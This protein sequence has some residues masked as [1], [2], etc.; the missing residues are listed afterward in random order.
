MSTLALCGATVVVSIDPVELAGADVLIDGDR[1]A[2]VGPAPPAVPRRDCSGTLIVPGNVCAHTHLYSALSRG[3]PYQLPPPENFLQILQR[4][5]WRLDRALDERSIRMSALI[6]GLDALLAGTTTVFDH[7]ASPNFIDGSLDI[8]AEA[9]AELGLRSVLCYEVTDRDGAAAAAAGLAENSRFCKASRPL[10]GEDARRRPAGRPLPGE[11][12]GSHS[13]SWSPPGRDPG[14]QPVSGPLARGL[15]GAHASFTLSD[16][17]LDACAG[18]AA[19][20]RAGVHIHVAEDAADQRDAREAHGCS[21]VDRLNAAGVLT[22][23]ALLAHCVHVDDRERDILLASGATIAHNA[24]SNM[25]NGVGYS[26]VTAS[27][28]Q[29]LPAG[30]RDRITLGTD[31]IGGDMITESQVA[32]FR[33][34]EASVRT[35]Q[36]WPLARLAASSRAA[37]RAFGEPA[38]GRIEAGAPADLA[39]LDYPAP[40]RVSVGSLAG[41]WLFGLSPAHVRDVLVAGELVVADRRPTRVDTDRL[42]AAAAAEVGRL[43]ARL[44]DIPPHGFTPRGCEAR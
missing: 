43:R 1:I 2:A 25:N 27:G 44:A 35:P 42:A 10:A 28:A 30:A 7:H 31:G 3:L 18:T 8:V 38:L 36:S 11:G 41:H 21:V 34:R 29:I 16:A 9:L 5:W 6:G 15:I 24:R 32:F 26:P 20:A 22:E 12:A 23:H 33:A 17:T 13:A 4:I 19:D 39:V 37:G 14:S 40:D